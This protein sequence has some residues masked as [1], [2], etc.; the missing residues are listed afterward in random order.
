MSHTVYVTVNEINKLQTD[1][2]HFID[3][4]VREQ[5]TPVPQ[6]EIVAKMLRVGIKDLTTVNALN[7]LLHKGYIRRASTISNK[8]YYVQL[9][10][11]PL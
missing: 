5:K 6:K 11:I 4:W 1:I 8:T 7:A 2:M 3:W 10:T 9:R